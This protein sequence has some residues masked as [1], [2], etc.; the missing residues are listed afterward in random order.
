MAG[1]RVNA[2]PKDRTPHHL[3]AN[4]SFDDKAAEMDLRTGKITIH[5]PEHASEA[6]TKLADWCIRNPHLVA[7]ARR[8]KRE[9]AVAPEGDLARNRPGQ[10]LEVLAREAIDHDRRRSRAWVAAQRVLRVD[11]GQS[12]RQGAKGERLV[13]RVAD[14][15]ARRGPWRVVHSIPLG[16]GGDIDH[17]LIGT[18]GVV[19]I[20]TKYHRNARISVS[21]RGIWVNGAQTSHV[22]KAR[23][24]KARAE[25]RLSEACGFD[26]KV[27]PVIAMVN[28]GRK[29]K[30]M[31]RSGT[32]AGFVV[33]SNL[34]LPR[35]LWDVEDGLLDEQVEAIYEAARRPETWAKLRK[36]TPPQA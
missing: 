24:L 12:F 23:D 25:A 9:R 32:P 7:A 31:A 34:N 19:L 13:G 36:A 1:I 21:D 8:P 28:R 18:D 5:M 17:L 20:D 10:N 11:S 15:M 22:K 33:A 14:R 4:L 6:A 35:A 3:Y 16:D 30:D 2:Y 27:T 26:V 29:A